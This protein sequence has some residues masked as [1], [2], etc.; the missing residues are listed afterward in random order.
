VRY[1]AALGEAAARRDRLRADLEGAADRGELSLAFQPVVSTVDQRV[2]G[3]EALLRWQHPRLGQIPP[4]EMLPIAERAGLSAPLHRWVL[5]QATTAVAALPSVGEA[6]QLGV[7]ISAGYL[8]GGTAVA[9]VQAA[10]EASGLP[11]ER[12]VLEITEAAMSSEHKYLPLDIETLRLM[13]VHVALDDFGTGASTLGHL[14]RLPLD[15]LKIDGA[16]VARVDKD[17]RALALCESIVGIGRALG[18]RVGAEGVETPAQLAAL[19]GIGCSFAQGFLIAR[20]M[21]FGAFAALLEERAGMLWPGL[22][23]HR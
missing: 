2:T 18:L 6:V 14:T 21:P 23:G 10:L 3:V 8:A 5:A 4:A 7:N 12:L 20:P 1:S 9:D 22:V 16:L 11:A 19:C 13:G 17:P 15:H